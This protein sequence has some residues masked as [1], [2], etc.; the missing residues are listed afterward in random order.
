MSFYPTLREDVQRAKEILER[1]KASFNEQLAEHLTDPIGA[2]LDA[3]TIDTIKRAIGGTIYGADT[4]AAYKLLES[5]VE[6]IETM[7][8]KVCELAM[9]ARRMGEAERVAEMNRLG[10]TPGCTCII[11]NGEYR[12]TVVG[13]CPVH[14][15]AGAAPPSITCPRCGMTSYN[16]ND[17]EQ[18]YCGACHR[19]HDEMAHDEG[20]VC[21]NC[22]HPASK[23]GEG[24]T[25]RVCRQE[26]CWA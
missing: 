21:R 12:S 10:H 15:R 24:G 11:V 19:F 22:G 18:K 1:G 26:G 9:R 25:C 13:G 2:E 5:F 6:V 17:I 16:R 8:V 7:N 4:Y 20:C 23:H 3:G 14:P